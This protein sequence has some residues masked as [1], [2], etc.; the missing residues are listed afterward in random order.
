MSGY[1]DKIDYNFLVNKTLINVFKEVLKIV[2]RQ[3]LPGDHHLYITFKTNHPKTIISDVLKSQYPE[4]MTIVLQHYF[5]SLE[6]LED[7]FSVE[8]SFGGVSYYLVI[9]F[10]AV[11]AF[12]DPSTGFGLAFPDV[13]TTELDKT[14]DDLG[15]LSPKKTKSNDGRGADVVSID[16]FRNKK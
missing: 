5:K 4:S 7:K 9:P 6:V 16:A 8:L 11:I 10:D 2:E 3:G 15:T 13:H 14:R 12:Q 1:I